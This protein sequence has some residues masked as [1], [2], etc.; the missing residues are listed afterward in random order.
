MELSYERKNKM[1]IV[2]LFGE[3]D[4]HSA[5]EIRIRVDGLIDTYNIDSLILDFKNVTFMDSSGIGVV[6]GRH[7]KLQ[8]KK[9]E[10]A[11]IN[12]SN[13]VKVIFDLSG[14]FKIVKYYNNL[15]KAMKALGGV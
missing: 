11:L 9:G 14:V 5:E 8:M 13:R 2:K 1:L 3:L 12:I 7:K 6:I 10:T 4:H 15:D